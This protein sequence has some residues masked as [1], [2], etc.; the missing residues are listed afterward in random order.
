MNM[1]KD[2][3]KGKHNKRTDRS[4]QKINGIYINESDVNSRN[5]NIISKM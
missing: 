2:F 3:G 1:F 4:S 5:K